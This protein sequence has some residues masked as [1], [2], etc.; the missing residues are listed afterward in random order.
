MANQGIG[1][2]QYFEQYY[3]NRTWEAYSEI[4]ALIVR[5]STPGPILDLGCGTG[6]LVECASRWG[7]SCKG[8]D[9]SQDAVD[10]A[11]KRFPGLDVS[12]QYFEAPLPMSDGAFS[13]VVM[14]QVI[15][16]LESSTAEMCLDEA[17][18][19]L[20]SGGML[21]V[22][23]P[24]IFNRAE[25]E[26]D[27]THVR[28]YSPSSLHHLLS[29]RGFSEIVPIDTPLELFGNGRLAKRMSSLVFR[30]TG[31]ERLSASASCFAFKRE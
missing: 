18:R 19:V 15:E 13:S 12:H 14:N 29:S 7:L 24:S 8:V 3:S 2:K 9:G 5:H 27:R 25:A 10:I 11:K 23:S 6:L 26:A 1:S 22:T 4:V 28:M 31:W 30:M 16:H 20:R 17:F 21:L